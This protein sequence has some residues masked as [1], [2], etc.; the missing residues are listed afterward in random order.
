[1]K[2]NRSKR[3]LHMF[4]WHGNRNAT[5]LNGI[6]QSRHHK[7]AIKPTETNEKTT[8]TRGKRFEN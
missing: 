2:G 6:V 1:M 7:K 5:H 3:S 8:L 4:H